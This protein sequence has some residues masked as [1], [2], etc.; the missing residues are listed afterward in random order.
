M[1]ITALITRSKEVSPHKIAL[2]L[3]VQMRTYAELEQEINQVA[4]TLHNRGYRPGAHVALLLENS[5]EFVTIFLGVVKAGAVP[6]PCDPKWSSR[7]VTAVLARCEPDVLVCDQPERFSGQ[8]SVSTRGQIHVYHLGPSGE[9]GAGAPFKDWL[10]QAS[11]CF[12]NQS[13]TTDTLFIGFT[14]GTTGRPK[15]YVRSQQSWLDS[16]DAARQEL[17]LHSE[18]TIIAPGPLVHSLTLFAVMHAL[19]M[20]ATVRLMASFQPFQLLNHLQRHKQ[21]VLFMVPT[22]TEALLQI[23]KKKKQDVSPPKKLISSGAKW[24]APSKEE[25]RKHLPGVQIY[26]F[27][28]S[29]E[30]SF[31]SLLNPADNQ[32]KPNAVGRPFPGVQLSIL[33]ENGREVETNEVGRLYVKSPMIF[34][35]YYQEALATAEAINGDWL[36]LEDYA[37]IDEDGFLYIVGRAKHMIISSGLNIYPEEIE[38]VLRLREEVEEVVVT[39]V[40]DTS[41]GEKVVAYVKWRTEPLSLKEIKDHCRMYLASYKVPQAIEQVSEFSYTSSGK[42]AR[43]HVKRKGEDSYA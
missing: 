23:I 19:T 32:T 9:F 2:Q 26:E 5:I 15:G 13:N 37:R 40:A 8:K 36:K 43:E 14:S 6:I 41:R 35:G 16:F 25:A 38:T 20:G 17:G 1:S 33:A 28:G 7:E 29:S 11:A 12:P 10:N 39:G 4:N 42:I 30:A 27:Y 3:G 18:H 34:S 31:V 22:M 21:T 24:P